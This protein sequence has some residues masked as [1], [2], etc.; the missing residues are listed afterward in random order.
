MGM[1]QP[2]RTTSVGPTE[3]IP[4]G[5]VFLLS[6]SIL[7]SMG[8]ITVPGAANEW[9]FDS[10]STKIS[11]GLRARARRAMWLGEVTADTTPTTQEPLVDLAR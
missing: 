9:H 4:I 10:L 7:P 8:R 5:V 6:V 3:A 11:K 2:T 1:L